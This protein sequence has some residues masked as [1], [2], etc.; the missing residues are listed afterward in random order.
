MSGI[1]FKKNPTKVTKRSGTEETKFAKKLKPVVAGL[2]G[3][4]RVHSELCL[5]NLHK[6]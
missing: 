6:F 4:M 5:K 1:C 3:V 2:M